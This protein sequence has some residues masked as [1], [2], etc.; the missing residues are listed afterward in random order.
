[1]KRLPAICLIILSACLFAIALRNLAHADEAVP[2]ELR[3][4][5]KFTASPRERF[6]FMLWMK[7]ESTKSIPSQEEALRLW[8]RM[9]LREIEVVATKLDKAKV[10]RGEGHAD[11]TDFSDEQG[12]LE[13]DAD[14]VAAIVRI[15]TPREE[16]AMPTTFS[17]VLAPF[18]IRL[19][20]VRGS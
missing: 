15:V 2:A 3:K 12:T 7:G 20:K 1:M 5:V 4:R 14:E 17:L 8:G 19:E 16:R 6:V 13:A 11:E 18:R 9:K 10:A